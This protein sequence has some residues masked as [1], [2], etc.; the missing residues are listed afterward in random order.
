MRDNSNKLSNVLKNLGVESGERVLLAVGRQIEWYYCVIGMIRLGIV[1]MPT[2]VL[3]TPKDIEYRL[4][5]SEASVVIATPETADV[6]DKA[7]STCPSVKHKIVIN[8][9]KDGWLYF[10]DL[11][12]A[13]SPIL[14]DVETTL[15][16]QPMLIFFTSGTTG[17][18]KMV[19][20]VQSYPLC[21]L[22]TARIQDLKPADIQCTLS[23]TGWAKSAWGNI[24]GQ[25]MAGCVVVQYRQEGKFNPMHISRLLKKFEISV[26]CAP[27]TAYRML[28]QSEE[29]SANNYPNLRHCVSAGEA[30]NPDL[31]MRWNEL[32]GH[33][34]YEFYGQSETGPLVGNLKMHRIKSGSMGKAVPG[35]IVEI[36][37]EDGKVMPHGE[38]G[39][40][41]VQCGTAEKRKIGVFRDYWKDDLLNLKAFKNGFYLTQDKAFRDEEGYFFF[42]GRYDDVFKSSGY[43]IGPFEIESALVEHPAISEAAIIG[44][45]DPDGVRGLIVKAY[46]VLKPGITATAKLTEEIQEFSKVRSGVYKYPRMIEYIA[47]L[48]KTISGKVQ[49][50][51]LKTWHGTRSKL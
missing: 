24:F 49:R 22:V 43:R 51:V 7:L 17:L 32:T 19:R 9:R 26:F 15:A 42:V 6:I 18:P 31:V 45:P 25:W 27:P 23:D 14:T 46:I 37:N 36:V 3:A 44:V 47:E 35:Y 30:L 48:P 13:A 10:D 12:S 11:M 40:I 41:A 5:R 38:E 39:I 2:T 33:P 28:L 21:H 4:N 29:F 8:H 1:Y 34:I 20:H 16:D 50:N